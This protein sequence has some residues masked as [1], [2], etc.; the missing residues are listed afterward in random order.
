MREEKSTHPRFERCLRLFGAEAMNKLA[1]SSV[2]VFGLGGVGSYA[3]E[4]LA[5][6]GIGT[7]KLVDFDKICITNINR[8]LHA[9]H[10]TI[11][12]SKAKL[13]GERILKINPDIR[14]DV[15]DAFY[16]KDT[17]EAMLTPQP[18]LVIDCID[19]ITAKMHLVAE[20]LERN[21]P[22][23]TSLG[24]SARLDPTRIRIAPL[25]NTHSDP[26]GRAL[27]KLIRRKHG[28]NDTQL[29]DA[30]AV[31]SDEPIIQ[32]ALNE[33]ELKCGVH[34]M[35][36]NGKNTH[37]TCSERNIIHGTVSFVTAAF[38][39]AAASAAVRM[40]IG[41]DPLRQDNNDNRAGK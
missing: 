22:L 1:H 16:D 24:A 38:G 35:C 23:V 15:V 36:P 26:L 33:D 14:L 3:A 13:M 21:I 39:M 11:G 12:Q 5:R 20:C 37:H 7:L 30:V 31:F 25:S 19:N 41:I 8:Q 9:F 4:S 10:D 27:R 18:D 40:L 29:A 6:T 2:S 28:I 34:C 17:S 32:P